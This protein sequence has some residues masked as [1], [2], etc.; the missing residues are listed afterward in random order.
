MATPFINKKGKSL[1]TKQVLFIEQ[2]MKYTFIHA[3]RAQ[4]GSNRK[5]GLELDTSKMIAP[6][7]EFERKSSDHQT[8]LCLA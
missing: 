2:S 1:F 4:G 5:R 7:V 3:R 6:G 8:C